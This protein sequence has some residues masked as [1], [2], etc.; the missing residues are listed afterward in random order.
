MS[1]RKAETPL[2]FGLVGGIRVRN[3]S[4]LV[5]Q[6]RKNYNNRPPAKFNQTRGYKIFLCSTHLSMKF[7]MLI[8]VKMPAIVGI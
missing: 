8:N 1:H 5:S 7:I 6:A 3:R 4:D 2:S